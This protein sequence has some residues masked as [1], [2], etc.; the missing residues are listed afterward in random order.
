VVSLEP[1]CDATYGLVATVRNLGSAALPSGVVVGFYAGA[2]TYL[3]GGVTNKTLYPAEAEKVVLEL[4]SVDPAV[5]NGT[6]L[7]Y[8]V[9]DDGMPAH[10]TSAGQ[11]HLGRAARA[12]YRAS[13]VECR[14]WS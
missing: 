4:P 5:E 1:R 12:A 8:A 14:P 11:Q 7:V 3:G 6:V 13:R 10:C 9:V 2:G